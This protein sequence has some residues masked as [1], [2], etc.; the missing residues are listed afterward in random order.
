MR[1]QIRIGPSMTKWPRPDMHGDNIELCFCTGK[2]ECVNCA[3]RRA[4]NRIAALESGMEAIVKR[5][6]DSR[7][8]SN[9]NE[10]YMVNVA[11]KLMET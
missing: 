7:N 5:S 3:Y 2:F 10:M 1:L 9:I 6:D 8:A 4:I 11:K